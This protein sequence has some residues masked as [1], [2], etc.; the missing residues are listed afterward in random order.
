MVRF[1]SIA[2]LFTALVAVASPALAAD[3]ESRL[4]Y[5]P[6]IVY[7]TEGVQWKVGD[8]VNVTWDASNLP[9]EPKNLTGAIRL[10][11]MVDGQ[12]GENLANTLA[13]DFLIRTGN[14]TF[15]V[16]NVESRDDYIV[17]LFGDS[18]NRSPKFSIN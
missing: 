4:V 9:K 5:V 7:P 8:Q 11:H 18:G 15:T 14:V 2:A 10:G 6:E 12:Q 1:T 3:L 16:P 17:V 13:Q